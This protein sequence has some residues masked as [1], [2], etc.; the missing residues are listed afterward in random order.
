MYGIFPPVIYRD[1]GSE[2]LALFLGKKP[3]DSEPVETRAA[4]IAMNI[5]LPPMEGVLHRW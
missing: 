1:S 2:G 3:S 4:G 5:F